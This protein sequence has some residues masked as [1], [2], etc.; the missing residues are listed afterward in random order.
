MNTALI[1]TGRLG[2]SLARALPRRLFTVTAFH[3]RDPAAARRCR[4]RL[5]RG[6]VVPSASEAAARADLIL[7]CVP[8]AAVAAAAEELADRKS[9]V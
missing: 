7:I 5:G 9:V 4:R 1:G 6:R 8:D 2:S 3:D